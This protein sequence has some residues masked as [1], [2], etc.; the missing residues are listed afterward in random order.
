MGYEVLVDR[1]LVDKIN[2]EIAT[3]QRLSDQLRWQLDECQKCDDA[4][5]QSAVHDEGIEPS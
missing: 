5:S 2:N 3:S 1:R 4:D